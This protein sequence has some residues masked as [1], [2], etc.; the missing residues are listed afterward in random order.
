MSNS[1]SRFRE[2]SSRHHGLDACWSFAAGDES[3][4]VI[5]ADGCFDLIVRV[6]RGARAAAFLYEPTASAQ[7][8]IVAEGA[9]LLGVRLRPGFG[10]VLRT[11]GDDLRAAACRQADAG[12]G[13]DALE[14]LVARWVGDHGSPPAVVR[15]FVA[16]A[17]HGRGSLRLTAG[18]RGAQR[19][20]QRAARRFLGVTPKAYLRIERAQAARVAIRQGSP[21]AAVAADLGYSDQ[22][23]L[24]REIRLLL[25]ATP[26][27]LRSVANVQDASAPDR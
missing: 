25:G 9:R 22:A 19:E 6:D 1:S 23:H 26:R 10:G 24:T 2:R 21:L 16:W 8:A 15:D 3:R 7:P 27:Q 12:A 13:L 18:T 17:E 14:A 4:S 5:P 20:L 11:R